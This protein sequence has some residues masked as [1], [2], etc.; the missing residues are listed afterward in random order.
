MPP[1]KRALAR[2]G[3]ADQDNKGKFG[4]GEFHV[5]TAVIRRSSLLERAE[6]PKENS[7]RQS[8]SASDPTGQPPQKSA[9]RAE[10]PSLLSVKARYPKPVRKCLF[11][12]NTAET[13]E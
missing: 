13:H 10:E 7:S 11:C 9:E 4:N 6:S 3:H 2:T 5:L 12:P 8:E 1:R